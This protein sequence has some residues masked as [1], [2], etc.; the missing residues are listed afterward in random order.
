MTSQTT[1][2]RTPEA[3]ALE[4]EPAPEAR[5]RTSGHGRA[6]KPHAPA[7]TA[8]DHRGLCLGQLDELLGFH[9]RRAQAMIYR[10]FAA[11]LSRLDLTQRQFAVLELIRANPGASQVDLATVLALDRPATMTVVDKL[12]Q[13]GLV[14]RARSASDRRRQEIRLTQAGAALLEK[15]AKRVRQHDA[16]FMARFSRAEARALIAS[17][18]LLHGQGGR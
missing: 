15:A 18:R 12:E 7:A 14:V 10:D 6:M 5:P 16:R 3:P 2:R 9:L 11:S 8:H 1:S 13:R 4:T 17:L